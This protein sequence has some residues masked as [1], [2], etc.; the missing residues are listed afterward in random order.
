MSRQTGCRLGSVLVAS[1][2][3]TT[4]VG[5]PGARGKTASRNPDLIVTAGHVK[6]KNFW[7]FRGDRIK[8]VWRHRTKND[9]KAQ[10]RRSAT[11]FRFLAAHGKPFPGDDLPVP[12]L[13]RGH[14]NTGQGSFRVHFDD[15]WEYGTYSMRICA[16]IHDRV[17]E[18]GEHNNCKKLHRIFVYPA[19]FDGTISGTGALD[20]EVFPGVVMSWQGHVEFGARP[21]SGASSPDDGL[22][23]YDIIGGSVTFKL[24]GTDDAG[25]VWAGA[26]TYDPT[27]WAAPIHLA[28]GRVPHY[29]ARDIVKTDYHFTTTMTCPGHQPGNSE[30]SPSLYG[31]PRWL[32]TGPMVRALKDPGL[33]RL[34]GRYTDQRAR[35]NTTFHWDLKAQD[36]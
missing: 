7:V 2:A 4:I 17:D 15:L 30:I 35:G 12:A 33:V 28:F 23:D 5:P 24:E 3:F 14:T 13:P 26:G 34:R 20:Q 29:S 6:L 16:D 18:G 19:T 10:S 36:Q 25:C 11:G 9:G 32:D 22:L 31:F 21:A 8:F 1:L 27:T